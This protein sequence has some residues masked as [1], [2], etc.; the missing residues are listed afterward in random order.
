MLLFDE[1]HTSDWQPSIRVAHMPEL[2]TD[3]HVP[4]TSLITCSSQT[5]TPPA[6]GDARLNRNLICRATE[7][8]S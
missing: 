6:C 2:S 1:N 3:Q 4:E 7:L 8:A 5:Q